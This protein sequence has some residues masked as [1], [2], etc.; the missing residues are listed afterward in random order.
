MFLAYGLPGSFGTTRP[1]DEAFVA[2]V[3]SASTTAAGS[4]IV[5]LVDDPIFEAAYD[6][7][8]EDDRREFAEVGVVSGVLVVIV[9]IGVEAPSGL[10]Q[11]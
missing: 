7:L 11:S 6:G 9:V 1:D 4:D 2:A 3:D 5:L 8:D 10:G